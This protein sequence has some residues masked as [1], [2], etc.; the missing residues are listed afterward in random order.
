M[1]RGDEAA[2]DAVLDAACEAGT[3]RRIA[4]LRQAGDIAGEVVLPFQGGVAGYY[5][6]A[7]M[8]APSGWLCVGA[9]GIAPDWQGAGHGRRLM[10]VLSQ[11]AQLS[12]RTVIA[13]GPLAFFE[14]AGFARID[15]AQGPVALAGPAPEG[16]APDLIYPPALAARA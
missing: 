16:G 6:L 3:A 8:R 12:G 13:A 15:T 11:W 4:G 10:G 5:A 1:R 2:V 14:R 7:R 9:I